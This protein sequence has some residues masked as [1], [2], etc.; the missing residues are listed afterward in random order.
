MSRH[1]RCWFTNVQ[2][3]LADRQID[4]KGPNQVQSS[5]NGF[6]RSNPKPP[7]RRSLLERTAEAEKLLQI[8]RWDTW[9]RS[10]L[11]QA[12]RTGWDAAT[13]PTETTEKW[14]FHSQRRLLP[15]VPTFQKRSPAA[16]TS[17]TAFTC[18]S[19]LLDLTDSFQSRFNRIWTSRL[20]GSYWSRLW[21]HWFS[22]TLSRILV[23]T[24]PSCC[25]FVCNRRIPLFHWLM[26]SSGDEDL[27]LTSNHSVSWRRGSS[28]WAR[29]LVPQG[30][31]LSHAP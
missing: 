9:G 17:L 20:R 8:H 19:T 30:S 12:G 2:T 5:N 29:L 21:P 13:E 31:S 1:I 23:F 27:I 14:I 10:G 4:P 22:Y 28:N 7:D 18:N 24:E 6:K 11:R 16:M 15:G 26:S 3:R 25:V